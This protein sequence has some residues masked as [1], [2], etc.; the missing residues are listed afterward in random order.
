MQPLFVLGGGLVAVVLLLVGVVYFG[1]WGAKA[2]E[3][4]DQPA[5]VDPLVAGTGGERLDRGPVVITQGGERFT[6]PA[7]DGTSNAVLDRREA[8]RPDRG[9][10]RQSTLQTGG[11]AVLPDLVPPPLE[12]NRGMLDDIIEPGSG[13][14]LSPAG[15]R[16]SDRPAEPARR[17][18]DANPISAH[19]EAADALLDRNDPLAARQALWDAMLMPGLDEL[20]LAALRGRLT[21]LNRDLVF[22]PV[23]RRGDPLST[24]YEVKAGDSLSRIAGR[25]KLGTHWKLIQRING[26]SSPERIRVGQKLKLVAGTFHAVV[27]KSD[28]R[29][30]LYHGET[31]S[32]DDWVFIASFDVGLGEGDSTPIGQFIV[33]DDGK[34][35]NPGWVNPRNPAEK[36]GPDDPGNPIGEFWVGLDGLGDA[37]AYTG[38]GIHGTIDPGSIGLERSMGCVRLRPDDIALIY[39]VMSEGKSL[40]RI[41]R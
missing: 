1:P 7:D 36:F 17:A 12:E 31:E 38:Y 35:A 22:G 13:A 39:E 8:D 40:V 33:R 25:E 24:M 2:D 5:T 3:P 34:L 19:I 29:M 16:S 21:D 37:A 30:D 20:Q 18:S 14:G 11:D 10:D 28:F 9:A 15:G 23:H 4:G 26:L 41:R 6:A 27:D 32:P